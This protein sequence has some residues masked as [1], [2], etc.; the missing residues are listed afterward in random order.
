MK[1]T[2]IIAVLAGVA[3]GYVAS[4]SLRKNSPWKDAYVKGANSAA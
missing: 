2:Y 4:E 1:L 3:V